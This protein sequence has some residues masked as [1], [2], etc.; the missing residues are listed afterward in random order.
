MKQ[1]NPKIDHQQK[2]TIFCE[3]SKMTTI[4][5]DFSC[6][7]ISISGDFP[8]GKTHGFSMENPRCFPWGFPMGTPSVSEVKGLCHANPT[9]RLPMKKGGNNWG[10]ARR[11]FLENSMT[12]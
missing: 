4:D 7:V 8:W 9:E 10:L 3:G 12:G 6:F 1:P 5:F 2:M 11:D